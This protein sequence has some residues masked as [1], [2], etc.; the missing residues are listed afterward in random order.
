MHEA[1]AT[2]TGLRTARQ[3]RNVY[4]LGVPE[5]PRPLSLKDTAINIAL[6]LPEKAG[7]INALALAPIIFIS[8]CSS[9]RPFRNNLKKRR[10]YVRL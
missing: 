2:A 7:I 1:L 4:Q 9:P 8:Q 10:L 5:Y 3:L 6:N